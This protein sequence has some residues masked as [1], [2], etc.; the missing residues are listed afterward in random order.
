MNGSLALGT[1]LGVVCEVVLREHGVHHGGQLFLAV[2]L[3]HDQLCLRGRAHV[4]GYQLAMLLRFDPEICFDLVLVNFWIPGM[5]YT[6]V[7]S[8]GYFKALF[9]SFLHSGVY[10]NIP[11]WCTTITFPLSAYI[12]VNGFC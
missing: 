1:G 6:K 8:I 7:V 11:L 4:L 10:L 12:I 2:P 5:P 9:C 3:L